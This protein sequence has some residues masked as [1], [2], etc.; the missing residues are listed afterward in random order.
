MGFLAG[1]RAFIIGVANESSIAFG[2]AKAMHREGAEIAL[3]FQNERLERKVKGCAEKVGCSILLPLDVNDDA[4]IDAAV[5]ELKTHWTDGLDILVHAVGFAPREELQGDYLAATTREGFKIA[6]ETSA[7]SFVA[8][9]K[10]T[11]DM[12][13]QRQGSA[14]TLTY[15][16]AERVVPNYNVM[17]LAKASLEASV[18]YLASS[19]G[20]AG[21]RVNGISAGPIRTLASAGISDFKKMLKMNAAQAPLKRTVTQDEV[22]NTAAFL[23][24]DLASGI[25]SE[26]VYVDAGYR[27]VAWTPTDESS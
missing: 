25:T 19:L 16:G 21:V 1:K 23:C 5:A 27:N 13:E 14:L 22:G 24:S 11:R 2:I 8:L 15:L 10:A 4:A 7:Y 9:A 18:R 6:H 3:T 17:G 20:G 26:I 12:L